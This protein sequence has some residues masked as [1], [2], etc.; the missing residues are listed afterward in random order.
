MNAELRQTT[1]D[2]LMVLGFSFVMT[3]PLI[4]I[5]VLPGWLFLAIYVPGFLFIKL[6]QGDDA[7]EIIERI[8]WMLVVFTRVTLDSRLVPNDLKWQVARKTFNNCFKYNTDLLMPRF[9]RERT[10]MRSKRWHKH[11]AGVAQIKA[12]LGSARRSTAQ[13]KSPV[14]EILRTMDGGDR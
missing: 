7:D 1:H 11:K 2:I 8:F 6:T 5:L 9:W 12:R 10:W 14:D 13:K 3:M 4:M